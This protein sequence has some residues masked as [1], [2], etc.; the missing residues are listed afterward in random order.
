MPL[1]SD[2]NPCPSLSIRRVLSTLVLD[3]GRL[4]NSQ[5]WPLSYTKWSS[6]GNSSKRPHG[7][8]SSGCH[9]TDD[10]QANRID[11]SRDNMWKRSAATYP[12]SKSLSI[13]ARRRTCI[14]LS[15]SISDLLVP[16]LLVLPMASQ[17]FTEIPRPSFL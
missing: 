1:N 15:G 17:G 11:S 9:F 7:K 10:W 12:L 16:S 13:R 4:A 6:S 2:S 8:I 14:R 5:G 3:I